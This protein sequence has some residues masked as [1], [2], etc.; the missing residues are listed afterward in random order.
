MFITHLYYECAIIGTAEG[1]TDLKQQAT[2][3]SKTLNFELVVWHQQKTKH[4]KAR[5]GKAIIRNTTIL[6]A[7]HYTSLGTLNRT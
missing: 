1:V 5:Q 4:S 6:G 2:S 3:Y 7:P